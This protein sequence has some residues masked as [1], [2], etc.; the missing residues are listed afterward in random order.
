MTEPTESG[1]ISLVC[2][3]TDGPDIEVVVSD[4]VTYEEL[5]E[6]F[7]AFSLA[8]GYSPK[9]LEKFGI[10]EDH[11]AVAARANPHGA[12]VADVASILNEGAWCTNTAYRIAA[13]LRE[14]GFTVP[15]PYAPV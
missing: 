6:A 8:V 3:R 15:L 11:D 5:L 14:S 12:L 9:T 1:E 4:E 10:G 7:A 13:R 2:E